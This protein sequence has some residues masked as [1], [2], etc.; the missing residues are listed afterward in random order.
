M[1]KDRTSSLRW[2]FSILSFCSS[3]YESSETGGPPQEGQ[4]TFLRAS[5]MAMFSHLILSF[6]ARRAQ[7]SAR[8]CCACKKMKD[9]C[10]RLFSHHQ[11]GKKK[12][13]LHLSPS[14]LE[15]KFDLSGVQIQLSAQM[16]PCLL[17]WMRALL[18]NSRERK[19]KKGSPFMSFCNKQKVKRREKD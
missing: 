10:S 17:I 6:S 14:V 3:K 12:E 16:I 9:Y 11:Q 4:I 19:E 2:A 8:S 1:K 5:R 15:P 18:K 13:D 7:L